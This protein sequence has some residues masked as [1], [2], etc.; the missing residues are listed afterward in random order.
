MMED[1]ETCTCRWALIN[2]GICFTTILFWQDPGENYQVLFL[3][4]LAVAPLAECLV[5]TMVVSGWGWISAAWSLSNVQVELLSMQAG[6]SFLL[7]PL[8]PEDSTWD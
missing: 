2:A 6:D 3:V 8:A 7:V 5:G 1:T 4:P